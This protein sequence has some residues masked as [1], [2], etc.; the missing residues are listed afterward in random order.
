MTL[1]TNAG[2][3]STAR[4]QPS[5]GVVVSASGT[6]TIRH[7]GAAKLRLRLTPTGRSYL[8]IQ[9]ANAGGATRLRLLLGVGVRTRGKRGYFAGPVTVRL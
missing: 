2:E 3:T 8:A 9:Q 5:P 4:G 1:Y 6:R 7:T